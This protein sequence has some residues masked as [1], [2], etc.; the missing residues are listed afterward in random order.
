VTA[1]SPILP[2]RSEFDNVVTLDHVFLS[3]TPETF[4]ACR[5]L[6][7]YWEALRGSHIMPSRNEFD[8]RGIEQILACTFVAEK[9]APSVA[10]IRVSGSVMNDALGMDVRGMPITAFFDPMSRDMLSDAT[11]DLFASPAMLIVD[12]FAPRRFGRKPIRARMLL[13]PM[14]D[15][16]GQ[17]TRLVGCLDIVDGLGKAPRRFQIKS[18]SRT[19]LSGEAPKASIAL[20]PFAS[21]EVEVTQPAYAFAETQTTFRSKRRAPQQAKPKASGLRLVVCND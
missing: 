13:L 8:P 21:S 16:L 3:D 7:A 18:I 5:D 2:I 4:P 11:R 6:Q 12:L 19:E 9:V 17:I 15:A 20:V 10:R 14:S 1:D